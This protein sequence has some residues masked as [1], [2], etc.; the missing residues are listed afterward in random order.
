MEI[1]YDPETRELINGQ[2]K[3][4]FV[5]H[6]YLCLYPMPEGKIKWR[7]FL[8]ISFDN[9]L[10]FNS[11]TTGCVLDDISFK[12]L[13]TY[14]KLLTIFDLVFKKLATK[15][16]DIYG[17]NK[18]LYSIYEE[19]YLEFNFIPQNIGEG[20]KKFKKEVKNEV[21]YFPKLHSPDNRKNKERLDM[22]I[23]FIEEL[24]NILELYSKDDSFDII[25]LLLYVINFNTFR[26][27]RLFSCQGNYK[28]NEKHSKKTEEL[29]EQLKPFFE[30]SN[31]RKATYKGGPNGP[32]SYGFKKYKQEFKKLG[33]KLP[34]ISQS[35]YS[36][37]YKKSLES[38]QHRKDTEEFNSKRVIYKIPEF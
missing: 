17:I 25:S 36:R 33:S 29:M 6:E 12:F 3:E 30:Q 4:S 7:F 32:I 23:T 21:R 22:F 15:D 18:F 2:T 38:E 26:M 27:E 28:K 19:Y 10:S 24:D 14:S 13:E 35:T 5:L 37:Y 20:Y 31:S 1:S 16:Q 9:K 34:K 11:F 8:N